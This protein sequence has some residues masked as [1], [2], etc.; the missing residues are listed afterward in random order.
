MINNAISSLNTQIDNV[1]AQLRTKLNTADVSD[2]GDMLEIQALSEKW[3]LMVNLE[4]TVTKKASD[5]LSKIIDR[6]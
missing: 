1:E 5:T 2:T 3:A 6:V 4:S